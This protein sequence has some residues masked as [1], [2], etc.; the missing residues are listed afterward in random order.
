MYLSNDYDVYKLYIR[1]SI[2]SESG[3]E[4]NEYYNDTLN[5]ITQKNDIYEVASKYEREQNYI[6]IAYDNIKLFVKGIRL[7]YKFRY[8]IILDYMI[9]LINEFDNSF[10]S[11]KEQ[12]EIKRKKNTN[13]KRKTKKRIR[14]RS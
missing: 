13:R 9:E 1:I 3:L 14:K 11:K 6:N 10:K 8:E 5:D 4:L 2:L 12:D 7:S